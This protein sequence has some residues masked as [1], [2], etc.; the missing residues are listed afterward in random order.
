M[1]TSFNVKCY[2]DEINYQTTLVE[3]KVK[4]Q[5]PSNELILS[6]NK[7]VEFNKQTKNLELKQVNSYDYIAWINGRFIFTNQRLETIFTSLSRWYNVEI[8]YQNEN[9]KDI[10]FTGK[11][12]RYDRIEQILEILE[13]TKKIEIIANNNSLTVKPI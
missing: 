8:I 11:L 4:Y 12:K 13:A 7:Q 6:P 5:N 1:G 2:A 10:R 3:G 9:V